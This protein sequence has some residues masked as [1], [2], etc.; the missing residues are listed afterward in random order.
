M[1]EKPPKV[2]LDLS[3][4]DGPTPLD[5]DLSEPAAPENGF[6]PDAT[7][8]ESPRENVVDSSFERLKERL[9][10][11]TSEISAEVVAEEK[12]RQHAIAEQTR[13]DA[14]DI[15]AIREKLRMD[16]EDTIPA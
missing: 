5:L 13:Q 1:S 9:M 7:V 4:Q 11:P 12:E 2:T 10:N 14:D 6:D 8:V 3:E 15:R 16:P